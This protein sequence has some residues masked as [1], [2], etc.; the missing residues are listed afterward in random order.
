MAV[1][2]IFAT[3]LVLT[4]VGLGL[5]GWYGGLA[6]ALSSALLIVLEISLSFDNAVVNAGILGRMTDRWLTVFL[7]LGVF[8]AV[9][10]MRIVFPILIVSISAGLTPVAAVQ[11]ALKGGDPSSPG[12]YANVVSSAE[13]LIGAFGGMF[14]MMVFLD[15]ACTKRKVLWLRAPEW[16]LLRI[17]EVP[18]APA[19]IS[20]AALLVTAQLVPPADRSSVLAAGVLGIVVHLAL[21]GLGTVMEARQ[22]RRPSGSGSAAKASGGAGLALFVYLEVLDASFSLDGVVGAFA[23]TVDP[24]VIAIGLGVGAFY[25]RSLTVLLVRRGTLAEF[26]YLDHGAH[27]A[28]GTLALILLISI[29]YQVPEVVTGLVGLGFIVS[30]VASSVVRNHRN[31]RGGA[32]GEPAADG[33]DGRSQRAKEAD[34]VEPKAVEPKAVEPEAVEPEP[35]SG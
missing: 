2:R 18:S 1:V 13:P 26:A 29:D 23:V 34:A 12:S 28:I 30:A 9:F 31:D 35:A 14:L 8:I 24:I 15:F 5:A 19:M 7:T 3:S 6:G 21:N 27:W 22:S 4:A 11:L 25:V 20:G 32:D 33:G 10:G 16:L 17:G